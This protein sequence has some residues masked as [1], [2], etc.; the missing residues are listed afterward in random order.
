[1]KEAYFITAIS[2]LAAVITVLWSHMIFSEKNCDKKI[3]DLTN[4][5]KEDKEKL[6]EAIKSQHKSTCDAHSCEKRNL[7]EMPKVK[8]NV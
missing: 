3:K 4:M 5:F 2:C 6:W 8:L 7:T 1:M